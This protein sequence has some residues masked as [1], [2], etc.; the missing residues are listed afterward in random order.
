MQREFI[1]FIENFYEKIEN[2]STKTNLKYFDA[3]ISGLEDDYNESA[4]LQLQISKLYSDKSLFAEINKFRDSGQ[5][6]D[7]VQKRELD[8]LY[9]DFAANQFDEKL[10]KE[11]IDLST[12]IEKDFSVFRAELNGKKITD[13]EIDE[14]LD[15]STDSV[16]LKTVW[17]ESKR[18]GNVVAEDVIKLVKLRNEGARNL[19][20]K[21]YHDMSLLLS[22]QSMDELDKVF[23]QLDN[24]ICKSFSEL[25]DEIDFYLSKKHNISKDE[26]M[27]LSPTL[28]DKF[29][30]NSA[31]NTVYEIAE[32][33]AGLEGF[34]SLHPHI[35][36]ILSSSSQ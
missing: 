18:I 35:S 2:L 21:N 10:H 6:T 23:I 15:T 34:S 32:K 13:N 29:A 31:T 17:E 20:F 25:K 33:V 22:E 28:V 4:K 9:N 26:I 5:I 27:K 14:I 24:M 8:L 11:I 12:K 16:E 30:L 36:H 19:G 3:S 1:E 7:T